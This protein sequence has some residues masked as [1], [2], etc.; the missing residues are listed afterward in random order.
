L[1]PTRRGG[2]GGGEEGRG[3]GEGRPSSTRPR[4]DLLQSVCK[5]DEERG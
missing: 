2:R 1:K 4:P 3:G 5:R